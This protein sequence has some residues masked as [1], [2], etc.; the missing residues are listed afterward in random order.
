LALL[1]LGLGQAPADQLQH[2]GA[3]VE[4]R[5]RQLGGAGGLPRAVPKGAADGAIIVA[6]AAVARSSCTQAAPPVKLAFGGAVNSLC[7]SRMRQL[8]DRSSRSGKQRADLRSRA[9]ERQATGSLC[10]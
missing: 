7:C 6:Q 4:A 1:A 3:V 5:G 10:I 8:H 9:V 2:S